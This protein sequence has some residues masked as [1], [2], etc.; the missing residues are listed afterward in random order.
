VLVA[1]VAVGGGLTAAGIAAHRGASTPPRAP[2]PVT[3]KRLTVPV[4]SAVEPAPLAA[5]PSPP[6]PGVQPAGGGPSQQLAARSRPVTPVVSHQAAAPEPAPPAPAFAPAEE[7]PTPAIV[8]KPQPTA[9]PPVRAAE[10]RVEDPCAAELATLQSAQQLLSSDPLRAVQQL[11]AFE[12]KCASGP[13]AQERLATRALALC[14]GGD[15]TAGRAAAE[16]LAARYPS[17]PALA[18]VSQACRE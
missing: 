4:L 13:L 3:T 11:D 12:A 6:A 2:N 5:E 10:A 1:S 9:A 15:R 7:A 14:Q 16:S 17:S 8:A 18:R